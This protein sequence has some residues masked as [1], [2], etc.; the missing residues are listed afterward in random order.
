LK[1]VP[2]AFSPPLSVPMGRVDFSPTKPKEPITVRHRSEV[3]VES[4]SR[5]LDST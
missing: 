5:T 1:A 2:R 3:M 4:N